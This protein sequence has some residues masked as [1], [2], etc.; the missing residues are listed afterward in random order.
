[1][2]LRLCI[3]T[4]AWVP[5]VNGV[6]RTLEAV[7]RELRRAGHTV[8][9]IGPDRFRSIPCPTYPEI[10]LALFPTNA[11]TR[12]IDDFKPDAI[13]IATEGP[14]G[15]LARR[16][17]RKRGWPFTTSFHTRF[18]DYLAARFWVPPDWTYRWL[19]S[20]HAAAASTM[21]ATQSLE[22]DLAGRG[23]RNMVRWTR[24]VD[25][26]MFRPGLPVPD[27]MAALPRPIFLHVGRIAVEKNLEAFLSLDLPGSKVLVGEGPQRAKLMERYP[28]AHFLGMKKGAELAGCYAAADAFVFPSRTDTFGLVLLEALACGTPVAA[29]PVTGPLDVIGDAPVGVLSDDLEKAAK[30]ALTLDPAACRQHAQGFSWGA[31]AQQFAENLMPT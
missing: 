16:L 4:D 18:P 27:A 7:E 1:M 3:I 29:Y 11:L 13:H 30:I 20:F 19:R 26:D 2:T 22:D 12:L 24:G 31:S 17:C 21:V 25:I 15:V 14:L 8:L 28:D 10:R 9:T 6:V 5:Q 23:F